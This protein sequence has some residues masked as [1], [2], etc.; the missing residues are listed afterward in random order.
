MEGLFYF[1]LFILE[2]CIA[3]QIDRNHYR[4]RK[5]VPKAESAET[6]TEGKSERI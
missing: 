6:K 4:S 5:Q 3:F 2:V 1:F